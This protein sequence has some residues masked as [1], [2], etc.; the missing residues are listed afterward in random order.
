MPAAAM[1]WRLLI[2]KYSQQ[3]CDSRIKKQE[4]FKDKQNRSKRRG[5]SRKRALLG[6]E[7]VPGFSVIECDSIGEHKCCYA[8]NVATFSENLVLS[9]RGYSGNILRT[10]ADCLSSNFDSGGRFSIQLGNWELEQR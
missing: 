9:R 4:K 6:L 1:H 3:S 7:R 10:T 5:S 2:A 8:Q